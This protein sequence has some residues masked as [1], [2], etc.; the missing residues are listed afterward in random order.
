MKREIV[1]TDKAP[2]PALGA[3]YSQAIKA[4]GFVFCSGQLGVDPKTG[5]LVG[6][7]VEE[8]ARQA[9]K[10][11]QAVLEASGSSLEKVVKTTVLLSDMN[12]F[13]KMNSAYSEFFKADPPARTAFQAGKLPLGGKV[14][15]DAIAII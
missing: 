3:P 11:L 1:K 5:K 8:Q 15:I 4:N 14:E 2:A 12:D 7:G 6:E 13:A 10:N 9:L